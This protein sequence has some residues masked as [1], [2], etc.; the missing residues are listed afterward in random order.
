M[1]L[2]RLALDYTGGTM[3][4]RKTIAL[5]PDE[6]RE[7]LESAHTIILTSIDGRGYPHPVAMWFVVDDDGTVVMTT[8]AK[9]QKAVNLR[10]D[11]RCALLVESG[12]TYPE[13]KGLLLRGRATVEQDE[14]KV[15]DV[16]ERVHAKYDTPG[17]VEGLRDAMRGQA[18]KRVVVRVRPER[19]S[20][21]DHGKLG[22]AY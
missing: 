2:R 8:F 4:R 22:G 6:Q 19:G 7:Y 15:L 12:R 16:L 9:S 1:L 11:P 10:R 13:L 18:R 17:P 3:Q 20:S 5:T 21:W 14:E